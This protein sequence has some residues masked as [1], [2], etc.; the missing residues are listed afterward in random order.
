MFNRFL[1]SVFPQTLV[2]AVQGAQGAAAPRA[3]AQASYT[4]HDGARRSGLPCLP[5]AL[6]HSYYEAHPDLQDSD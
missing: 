1:L 6:P 2:A 4:L 3:Q 5:P